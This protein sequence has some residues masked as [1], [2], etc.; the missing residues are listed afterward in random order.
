MTRR[1]KPPIY[2]AKHDGQRVWILNIGSGERDLIGRL[3]AE[4]RNLLTAEADDP[5]VNSA[6]LQRLF[7]R[8]YVDDDEKE[9]EY[10]RLMREE[11]VASRLFQIDAIS[12]FLGDDGSG[13]N[14]TLDEGE[15]TAL[16][17]SL[18]AVRIVLGTMLDVG[19]D[20]E[21]GPEV[22]DEGREPERELYGFLSW[23]LEWT[24]RALST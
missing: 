7:P 4:L 12:Q 21:I 15:V 3:L 14:V 23:L 19:E 16:M 5:A 11:L 13:R 8:V 20:D 2:A 18:N 6:L 24:V 10:Q 17:Q 9:A 22:A 1:F